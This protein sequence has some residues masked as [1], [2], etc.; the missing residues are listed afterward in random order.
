MRDD[1]PLGGGDTW[2]GLDI[3][4]QDYITCVSQHCGPQDRLV[5]YVFEQRLL[6]NGFADRGAVPR[7]E[8]QYRA[9]CSV[10]REAICDEPLRENVSHESVLGMALL[11]NAC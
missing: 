8:F 3:Q 11:R 4:W 1:H 2:D 6:R 7:D 9:E 5:R 10:V